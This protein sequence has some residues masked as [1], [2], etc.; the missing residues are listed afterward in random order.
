MV[1]MG[2]RKEREASTGETEAESSETEVKVE[3]PELITDTEKLS[4]TD[5]L[6][7]LPGPRKQLPP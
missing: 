6:D 7:E 2:K 5:L 3:T 4:S 1:S